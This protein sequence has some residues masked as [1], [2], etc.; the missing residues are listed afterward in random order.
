MKTFT[1]CGG[2][3]FCARAYGNTL[4]IQ[5]TFTDGRFAKK[6]IRVE[7]T[8]DFVY[9]LMQTKVKAHGG[10]YGFLQW[11]EECENETDFC[12]ALRRRCYDFMFD[13]MR[14]AKV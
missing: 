14:P 6:N 2:D 8:E 1:T 11:L 13:I 4:V 9:K 10:A 3:T 12:G 7:E 5:K